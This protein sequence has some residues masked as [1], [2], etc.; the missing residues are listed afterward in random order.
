VA[1]GNTISSGGYQIVSSGA[2]ASGTTVDAGGFEVVVSGGTTSNATMSGGYI[3]LGG[4][5]GLGNGAVTFAGG[6]TLKLDQSIGFTGKIAGFGVPGSRE[7][8]IIAAAG[9]RGHLWGEQHGIETRTKRNHSCVNWGRLTIGGNYSRSPS[10]DLA[11][12]AFG[13][14]T[15]LGFSEAS[16]NTSGTLTV[17]DGTHTASLLLLGQYVAGNF[18]MASDGNLPNAGTLVTDPPLTVASDQQIFMGAPRHG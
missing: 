5:N 17:S 1:N 6:G 15:T 10:I 2:S 3:E 14:N 16:N 4:G 12:I 13:A 7:P 9:N 11:D 18:H 8:R